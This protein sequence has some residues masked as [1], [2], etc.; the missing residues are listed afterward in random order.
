M[1][2][3]RKALV[4]AALGAGRVLAGGSAIGAGNDA[5]P[6]MLLFRQG[7][8]A[9]HVHDLGRARLE[10][11]PGSLANWGE[12]EVELGD[13]LAGLAH[14]R[15]SLQMLE[16]SDARRVLVQRHIDEVYAKTGHI[17]VQTRAGAAVSVDGSARGPA[18]LS[19][20]I[21]VLAGKRVVEAS[22]DGQ[23]AHR[24]IDVA[25]GVVTDVTLPLPEKAPALAPPAP[26]PPELSV[27]PPAPSPPPNSWW[28]APRIVGLGLGAGAVVAAGVATYFHAASQS[29][30]DDVAH[31]RG[32]G[33][34][35]QGGCPDSAPGGSCANL[36][37]RI[38]RI[39]DDNAAS[40]VSWAM[41]G[42]A[43]V[44]TAIAF[45]V[46]TPAPPRS[47]GWIVR[48]VVGF[49]HAGVEGEF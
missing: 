49:G 20:P 35:P 7:L 23:V 33:G 31:A 16:A 39:S 25:S 22:L 43:A 40:N 1:T 19:D 8:E 42:A 10:P 21:D 27:P 30:S 4:C 47:S 45:V 18:P 11:H 14:L 38:Q 41:A 9:V 36:Q 44:G 28:T 34:V 24:E 6:A 29:A 15:Q 13:L 26:A 12:T 5:E 37:S 17:T 48:P 2:R 3:I 46:G 32:A